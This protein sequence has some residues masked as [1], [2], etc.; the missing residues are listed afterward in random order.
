MPGSGIGRPDRKWSVQTASA[1]QLTALQPFLYKPILFHQIPFTLPCFT[2]CSPL[3][4]DTCD[5]LVT[6][7]HPCDIMLRYLWNRGQNPGSEREKLQKELFSFS[8]NVQYGFPHKPVAMD[9]DPHLKG[10]SWRPYY[11]KTLWSLFFEQAILSIYK[12]VNLIRI[13]ISAA[14]NCHKKWNYQ[15]IWTTR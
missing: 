5:S 13:M 14:C 15:N 3:I 4:H 10:G 6:L 1:E 8:K 2:I 12:K 7:W 11:M 9:W